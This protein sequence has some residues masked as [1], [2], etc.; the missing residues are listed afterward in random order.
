MEIESLKEDL[1]K[2]SEKDF[3]MKHIVKSHNW[4]LTEYLKTP[5]TDLVERL[6][7]MKEIVSQS[8]NIGFHSLQ[9]V[10][11]AKT[12]FSLSPKKILK[13]FHEETDASPSSDIDIALISDYWYSYLWNRI[14]KLPEIYYK[15][16]SQL[17]SKITYSVFKGFID[18]K[19]ICKLPILRKEWSSHAG[20]ANRQLQDNLDFVHPITY[21]VYRSWE[22][23]EDY[24]L[25]SIKKAKQQMEKQNEPI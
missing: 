1:Q 14:R 12:G 23:L 25:Y 13:P 8:F 2:L 4:Y 22:D 15:E 16:N 21:R 9:I 5:I 24:Q 10:G 17:F 6:D 19:D 18:A 7:K 11:S 3:F 20:L